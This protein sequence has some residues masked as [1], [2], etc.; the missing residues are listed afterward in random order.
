MIG[1]SNLFLAETI[2]TFLAAEV[3]RRLRRSRRDRPTYAFSSAFC[4]IFTANFISFAGL[5]QG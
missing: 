5:A 2:C 1:R 4:A 3:V